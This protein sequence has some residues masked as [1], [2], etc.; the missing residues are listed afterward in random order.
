MVYINHLEEGVTGKILKFADYTK[1]FS[2]TK[3]IGDKQKIQHDFNTLVKSSEKE[4]DL[5]VKRNANMKYQNNA[6]VQRLRVTRFLE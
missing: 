5:G 3:D 4:N 6:E 2:K 1:P